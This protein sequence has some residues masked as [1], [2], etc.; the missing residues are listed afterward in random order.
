MP[1]SSSEQ[2][3]ASFTYRQLARLAGVS[4]STVSCALRNRP[5]V[6]VEERERI[7]EIARK[8]GYK[9]NPLVTALM[10]GHRKGRGNRQMRA[11]IACITEK[12]IREARAQ[13]STAR[14]AFEGYRAACDEAGFILEEFTWEEFEE[15]PKRLFSV[16]RA[17]QVPG[18]IFHGG[19]V[20]EWCREGWDGFAMASVGNRM[21]S[22]PCDF[23]GADHFRNTL[24]AIR[25]L[26]ELGY[27]RIG[28]AM[29]RMPWVENT[30]YRALS[31][32]QGWMTQS[33]MG[34]G[35]DAVPPFWAEWCDGRAFLRWVCSHRPE[36]IIGA[37]HDLLEV[38]REAGYR[39]PDD[40]GF[41][42]LGL[43]TAWRDLAGVRQNNRQVGEAAAHL[44]IEQINRNAYG[45]PEH[46]RAV[47]VTGDWFAGPSVQRHM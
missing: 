14:E 16:L 30:E 6:S 38:L 34:A 31:A 5:G 25:S 39:F 22:V 42:H 26:T 32:Y 2:K 3:P 21:L 13:I 12:R 29:T 9:P 37:Q 4:L 47:L 44:V 17:R 41:A 43:D 11:I 35:K 24:I 20:P 28:F 45:V 15:S 33:G 1:H 10:S 27:R 7:R 46:P 18:V 8:A 19:D 36:V 23:A 40:I